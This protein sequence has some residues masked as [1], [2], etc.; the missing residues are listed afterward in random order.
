MRNSDDN[1]S[2]QTLRA[3]GGVP[4]SGGYSAFDE[5][6]VDPAL[7]LE[8]TVLDGR[9]RLKAILGV[10]GMGAVYEGEHIAIGN[11]VAVKV[12]FVHGRKKETLARF[13]Q[14]A[15]AA[16]TIGHPNIVRVH[17]L[18]LSPEGIPYLVMDY[19]EGYSLARI[20]RKDAPLDSERAAH[21]VEQILMALGAAHEHGIIHRDVKPENVMVGRDSKGSE[22]ARVL[23]FG[24][25][26]VRPVGAETQGLTQTG[27]VLG[28]PLFMAP[29]QARGDP[30]L[31][32]R[33]DLYAVGTML[34]IMLT[35]KAPFTADNYNQLLIKIVTELPPPVSLFN[36]NLNPHMAAV[37]EKAMARDR[38]ERFP[39]A[40]KFID[41]LRGEEVVLPKS[42]EDRYLRETEEEPP[43]RKKS[44]AVFVALAA[45]L[46]VIPF[47]IWAFAGI[48][49]GSAGTEV[50]PQLEEVPI[51]IAEITPESPPTKADEPRFVVPT[52]EI[53]LP[54]TSEPKLSPMIAVKIET[55]PPNA[56]VF[57]AGVEVE[58]ATNHEVLRLPGEMLGVKVE[59]EGY[60]TLEK[61]FPRD[62]DID[63]TIKLERR[64]RGSP[65]RQ[66]PS[67][68]KQGNFRY[69]VR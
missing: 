14:E 56:R 18:G 42:I 13:R 64:R 50:E 36:E 51:P 20:L 49:G 63:A 62:S 32:H 27:V 2:S 4:P 40:Q 44:L 11:K 33:L 35:G 65:P 58:D 48:F 1:E 43:R 34:Y 30:D 68:K 25:S 29:E 3:P 47:V 15:Q 38:D 55:D 17:D 57:V 22:I 37:V 24:I 7:Q 28:T 10:G 45:A 39:T 66:P 41:A 6:V 26:K 60:R 67:T 46:I 52:A 12:L 16:G 19:V 31:D 8:G 21:L 9:Y 23:D 53:V 69:E 54:P 61:V 59:A 5:E